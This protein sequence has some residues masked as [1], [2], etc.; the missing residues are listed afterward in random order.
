MASSSSLMSP[1]CPVCEAQASRPIASLPR[2]PVHCNVLWPDAEAARSAPTG[3]IELVFCES[4]GHSFNTAFLAELVEYAEGYE[5]SLYFSATFRE[6]AA[7]LAERLVTTFGLFGK[8]IVEIGSG[9]GDFLRALCELGANRGTGFDPSALP[10]SSPNLTFIRDLFS[11]RYRDITADFLV[12]RHVLEHLEAPRE[13]LRLLA[14]AL[15]A[16]GGLYFEVP[17]ADFLFA[18]GSVWD[19]IYPHVSY[20]SRSSLRTLFARAGFSPLAVESAFRGQFLCLEAIRGA[21]GE[22]AHPGELEALRKT[23]ALFAET[24]AATVAFWQSE[25]ERELGAGKRVVLWGAGAKAVSFLNAVPG[26]GAIGYAVDLNPKKHGLF[27]PGSGTEIVPPERLAELRPDL[28]IV[29]NPIYEP[30]IRAELDRLGLAGTRCRA[31]HSCQVLA[32]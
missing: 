14:P 20:F 30:E 22:N 16:E 3:E 4:C 13:L 11:D 17:N 24:Y 15:R 1:P 12:C 29:L 25:L 5:N 32:A 8:D 21:A 26:A 7:A 19:L 31:V 2:V 23:A 9:G 18:D 10:A 27:L 28:A 6:Y